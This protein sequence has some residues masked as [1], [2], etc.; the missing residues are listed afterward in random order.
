MLKTIGFVLVVFA[1]SML[2]VSKSAA[3][4]ADARRLEAYV[5]ALELLCAEVVTRLTPLPEV[6]EYLSHW[7]QPPCRPFFAMISRGMGE[8]DKCG[9]RRLWQKAVTEKSGL[10]GEAAQVLL[11]LGLSLG[12]YDRDVQQAAIRQASG[13]MAALARTAEQTGR[14]QGKMWIGLGIAGGLLL[15][16]VLV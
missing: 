5:S 2:G 16:V 11:A 9:F 7:T 14:A 4:H 10:T 12:R 6:M 1:G 8:L 13:R 3:L 15:A